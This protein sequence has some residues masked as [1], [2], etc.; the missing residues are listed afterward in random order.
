[1]VPGQQ[2][3]ML[4]G[5]MEYLGQDYSLNAKAINPNLADGTG[6]YTL[7]YLQSLSPRLAFGNELIF[8]RMGGREPFETGLNLLAK[9][10][11]QDW[12]AT[13]TIQQFVAL[14]LSYW[15]KVSE[16]VE[17]GSELQILNAGPMRSEAI[18]SVGAKFDY[19]QCIIRT[20]IDSMMKVSLLMEEK[21]F[22]GFSLL[23]S[24]ELDHLKGTNKFGLGVNLEN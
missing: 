5:E 15:Q 19:K 16:K 14:Q 8:Q 9:L 13:A 4:Q 3:F 2:Q 10:N 24:G 6:I 7:S 1:M 21:I 22:P 12:I 20:Q 23:L 17:L 11:G 18:T